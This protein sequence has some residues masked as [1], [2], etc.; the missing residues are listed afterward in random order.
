MPRE[1][2]NAKINFVSYVDKAANKKKFFMTKSS[3]PPTFEKEVKLIAKAEDEKKLVYGVVY[4]P[5]IQDAH[6]DF[7]SADEIQKAAHGFLKNARKIDKDHNFQGGVGEVVESYV[8]PA[9]FEVNGETIVKGSWVLVTKAGDE[10]W[11]QIKK[12]SITGYSMAGTAETVE[13]PPR[14]GSKTDE[15][16]SFFQLFK[17]FFAGDKQKTGE[18]E[19]KMKRSEVQGT[20]E[21]VLVPLLKRLDDLEG[22]KA[23]EEKEQQ[24]DQDAHVK[25]IVEDMLAPLIARIEALEKMRGASKQAAAE[26]EGEEEVKKSIWS[27]LL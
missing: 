3:E 18:E 13:H 9:D 26:K 8:A 24:T 2:K 11:E 16:G 14:A 27:G 22:D 23:A 20:I 12:G 1:L 17:Q 21:A 25:E 19:K 5:D 10:I 6:G 7:M 4:E 15:T